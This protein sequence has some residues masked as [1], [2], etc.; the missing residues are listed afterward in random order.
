M[1][2]KKLVEIRG[3]IESGER[4]VAMGA[5][6]FYLYK[7]AADDRHGLPVRSKAA[8]EIASVEQHLV[9]QEVIISVE[10]AV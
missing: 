9:G 2:R 3:K 1:P 6:P 7:I 8:L 4:L 10:L 5:E